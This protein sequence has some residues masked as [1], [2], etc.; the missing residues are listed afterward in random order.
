MIGLD[1]PCHLTD[2]RALLARLSGHA[3]SIGDFQAAE[4]IAR[5]QNFDL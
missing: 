1:L 2:R 5:Y 3:R 4:K